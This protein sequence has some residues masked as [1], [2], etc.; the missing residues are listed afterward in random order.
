[1]AYVNIVIILAVLQF[2]VFATKVG[3]A[4]GRYG[5][6]APATTGN[7]IFERYFRVQQNTLELLLCLLPALYLSSR[8]WDPVWSAVL[9]AIYLAGRE[10]Y[11]VTYVKD[12]AKRSLGFALSMFPILFLLLVALFGAVRQAAGF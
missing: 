8:T 4:R 9:G 2:I 6:K 7:E 11:A 1:M 3:K 5:I 10:I 12:P